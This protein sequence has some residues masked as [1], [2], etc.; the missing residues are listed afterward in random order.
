M[1]IYK[2]QLFLFI[3]IFVGWYCA[4]AGLCY[5]EIKVSESGLQLIQKHCFDTLNK[6]YNVVFCASEYVP[7]NTIKFAKW[8][9]LEPEGT[10]LARNIG[11]EVY[12][13]ELIELAELKSHT[14]FRGA[15]KENFLSSLPAQNPE[16]RKRKKEVIR[17]AVVNDGFQLSRTANRSF[18]RTKDWEIH[19]WGVPDNKNKA[20]PPRLWLS[21]FYHGAHIASI[22]AWDKCLKDSVNNCKPLFRNEAQRR[23]IFLSE[24]VQFPAVHISE[25]SVDPFSNNNTNPPVSNGSC[26]VSGNRIVSADSC[27]R[28]NLHSDVVFGG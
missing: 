9:S 3:F 26:N 12:S 4:T 17:I 7:F 18:V 11:K 20:I 25:T 2:R 16:P 5:P 22:I 15:L 23:G 10:L 28:R 27:I 6:R 1:Y 24:M 13:K 14:L 21:D 19:E 8:Y